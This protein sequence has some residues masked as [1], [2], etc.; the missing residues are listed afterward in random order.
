MTNRKQ[1][2]GSCHRILKQFKVNA[3]VVAA[4]DV[5]QAVTSLESS[6]TGSQ[7]AIL[8]P[9]VAPAVL[10]RTRVVEILLYSCVQHTFEGRPGGTHPL[11][12]ARRVE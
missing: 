3:Q 5:S 9:I 12:P 6:R 7:L 1:L 10:T 2:R 4:Q 11:S 8:P